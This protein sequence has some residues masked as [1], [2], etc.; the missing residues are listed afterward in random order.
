MAVRPQQYRGHVQFLAAVDDVVDPICPAG[1]RKPAGLVEQEPAAAVHQL[2][3]APSLQ[4][5]V[6]H[7]PAEQLMPSPKSYRIPIA[8]SFSIR[9][10]FTSSKSIRSDSSRRTDW[11]PGSG[12]SSSIWAR[13]LSSTS[14]ATG[15]RSV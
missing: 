12:D 14:A 6:P 10:R 13:V 1:H 7:P 9:Y 15:C 5:R 11:I 2:V 4:P 3:Q 8:V